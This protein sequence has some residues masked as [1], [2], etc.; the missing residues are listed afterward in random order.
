MPTHLMTLLKNGLRYSG[1]RW[2]SRHL[3]RA[4]VIH[5]LEVQRVLTKVCEELDTQLAVQ[6][7]IRKPIIHPEVPRKPLW[8]QKGVAFAL[9][10]QNEDEASAPVQDTIHVAESST[11]QKGKELPTQGAR[12][13]V[14]PIGPAVTQQDRQTKFLARQS[15]RNNA[16]AQ[17]RWTARKLITQENKERH[18][19]GNPAYTGCYN[20]GSLQ[21]LARECPAPLK[22]R[23]L[24]IE[25][26]PEQLEDYDEACMFAMQGVHPDLEEPFE[27]NDSLDTIQD[28]GCAFVLQHHM[29]KE[30]GEA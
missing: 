16:R 17:T 18:I 26:S 27:A 24:A 6:T 5:P 3:H 14:G 13:P 7:A 15:T 2:Q 20:C 28:T 8:R 12:K 30:M 11:A 22:E 4:G 25:E 29:N 10:E 21:H 19:P 9:E 23:I 1:V